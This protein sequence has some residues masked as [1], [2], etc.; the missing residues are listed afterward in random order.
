M[1]PY[2]FK[3][4]Y[5]KKYTIDNKGNSVTKIYGIDKE[6]P[7]ETFY[8]DE[9]DVAYNPQLAFISGKEKDYDIVDEADPYSKNFDNPL[10][11]IKKSIKNMID[12]PYNTTWYGRTLNKGPLAGAAL[13]AATGFGAGAI[14]D[15]ILDKIN[16]GKRDSLINLKL[17]GTLLGG[18]TMGLLGYLRERKN[19]TPE[20]AVV[21]Y[22]SIYQNPKNYILE[23]LQGANDIS[24]VEK[25]KLAAMVKNLDYNSAKNLASKVRSC[26]GVGVGILISRYLLGM[27]SLRGTL[28]GGVLGYF[29]SK[30]F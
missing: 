6:K 8:N 24:I 3:N 1:N 12:N 2:G 25:A 4:E 20:M 22:A 15:F 10:Y 9:A 28:F 17:L 26:L 13:G 30:L 23:S 27:T 16:G 5:Y 18:G 14:S 19:Q 11:K 21:K 29:G 7:I